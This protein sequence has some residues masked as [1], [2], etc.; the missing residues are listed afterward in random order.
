MGKRNPPKVEPAKPRPGL[1]NL[2]PFK[3][4]QSGNPSGRPRGTVEFSTKMRNAFT[5][6]D[7]ETKLTLADIVLSQAR[8]VFS[9]H[10]EFAVKFCAAYGIGL[11]KRTLDDDSV[12]QL[13]EEMLKA[14]LEE[15]RKRRAAALEASSTD[16]PTGS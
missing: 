2:R 16:N 9:P 10:W 6:A 7:P 11:P 14:A 5:E 12:K 15:S 1:A 8:N 4:G 13:A 3:K